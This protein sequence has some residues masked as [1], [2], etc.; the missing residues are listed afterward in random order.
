MAAHRKYPPELR[1]R[2]VAYVLETDRST[3]QV[4]DE[5]GIKYESLRRW[6][7]QAEA[8]S[9][10]RPGLTT[11][12]R[13]RIKELEREVRELRRTNEILKSAS[14]FFAKELDQPRTK[15]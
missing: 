13:E 1:E 2:A 9:G 11:D 6:V 7:V 14:A 10:K 3:R 8:D 4:A 5:L 12:E 15:R